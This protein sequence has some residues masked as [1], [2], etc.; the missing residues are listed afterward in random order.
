MKWKTEWWP[1][2][3][4]GNVRR[5]IARWVDDI[6]KIAISRWVRL[7]QD[8]GSGTYIV[9]IRLWMYVTYLE[10]FK[11]VRKEIRFVYVRN[12]R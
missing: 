10:N 2:R 11:Q 12:L 6:V 5:P 7:T 4:Y 1:R 3:G 8:N 9:E